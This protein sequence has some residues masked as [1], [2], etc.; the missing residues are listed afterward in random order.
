MVSVFA[1]LTGHHGHR[2]DD[3]GLLFRLEVF[4]ESA[5]DR[6]ISEKPRVRGVGGRR[7]R[8]GRLRLVSV[9]GRGGP[10]QELYVLV[11]L[12]MIRHGVQRVVGDRGDGSFDAADERIDQK[13]PGHCL[14]GDRH[15]D[16]RVA[17]AVLHRG[18]DVIFYRH[19]TDYCRRRKERKYRLTKTKKNNNNN[20]LVSTHVT[21]S[22]YWYRTD[23]TSTSVEVFGEGARRLNVCSGPQPSEGRPHRST[24]EDK[25]RLLLPVSS[26]DPL[27]A[28]VEGMMCVQLL[29]CCCASSY[30]TRPGHRVCCPFLK[31]HLAN[32]PPDNQSARRRPYRL[33]VARSSPVTT[34]NIGPTD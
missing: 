4:A 22:E 27:V 8:R 18:N 29:R 6:M 28:A 1:P 10:V 14:L 33:Q 24:A 25:R 3:G 21:R 34:A 15:G 32:C 31:T 12:R 30:K 26:H 16:G 23:T 11:E 20:K 17:S 5:A 19:V 13:R 2:L 9:R 7:K